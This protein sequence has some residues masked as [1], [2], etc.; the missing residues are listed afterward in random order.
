MIVSALISDAKILTEV[1]LKSKAYWGYSSKL[2]EGWRADLTVTPETIETCNVY[3]LMVDDV[4][5]G[6]YV[7]NNPKEDLVKLEMLFVLP[8]FIGKGIGKKLVVHAL[9]KAIKANA[10]TIELVADPNAIPFYKSQGFLEKG[11]IGSAVL[12]RFLSLM[13]KD[14]N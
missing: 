6:F 4:A 8:L 10:T 3:K 13:Q 9:K 1:A 12:G 7:L 14:L 2:I 5:V 11:K